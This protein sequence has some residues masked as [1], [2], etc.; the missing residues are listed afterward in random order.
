M[1]LPMTAAIYLAESQSSLNSFSRETID[2]MENRINDYMSL[3]EE[4]L[5]AMMANYPST[6]PGDVMDLEAFDQKAE[7]MMAA[8]EWSELFA[9][10]QNSP[11]MEYPTFAESYIYKSMESGLLDMV[12]LEQIATLCPMLNPYFDMHI[13][14]SGRVL[15]LMERQ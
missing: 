1:G 4:T 2:T 13:S 8:G 10:I 6:M 11:L 9:E 12:E 7:F 14:N 5:N 3:G 15:E